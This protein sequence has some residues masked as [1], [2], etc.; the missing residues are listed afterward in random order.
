MHSVEIPYVNGQTALT[1][2]N[3]AVRLLSEARPQCQSGQEVLLQFDTCR[4]G[5]NA[6]TPTFAIIP[7][8]YRSQQIGIINSIVGDLG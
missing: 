2:P 6:T 1:I 8:D 7:D 5:P 3:P 4:F